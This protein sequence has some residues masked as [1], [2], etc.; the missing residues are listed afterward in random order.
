[1]CLK[2]LNALAPKKP[3]WDLKRDLEKKLNR[4]DKMT[5]IA[6]ADLIRKRLQEE[7]DL[8]QAA[9]A[10]DNDRMANRNDDDD[11]E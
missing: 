3:N 7:G 1:M 9:Q 6:V 4:L 10:A 5:Q 11:Y 2:D 8:S